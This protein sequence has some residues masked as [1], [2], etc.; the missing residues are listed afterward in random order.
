M[1]SN[2]FVNQLRIAAEAVYLTTETEPAKLLSEL[3]FKAAD[4]IESL[5][6]DLN[7]LI[8]VLEGNQG[9]KV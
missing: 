3:F 2:H 5:Q 8:K 1:K 4:E 6:K 9:P 7:L